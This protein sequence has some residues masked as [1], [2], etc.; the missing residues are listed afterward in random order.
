[1]TPI[2]APRRGAT[3]IELLVVMA[4]AAALGALALA[5]LPSVAN[6]EYTTRGVAELQ[7]T[8]KN[9]QAMA[10]ATKL[11]RGVRLLVPAGGTVST[12]LQYIEMPPIMIPD[13]Q[14]LVAKPGDTT[15][16]N[17]KFGPQVLFVYELYDGNTAAIAN[18]NWTTL[19]AKPPAGTIKL[20]H[21]YITGLTPAQAAQVVDG[22]V[23]VLPNLGS[24]S[25]I[26][27][28]LGVTAAGNT[29]NDPP[30]ALPN[31]EV[32]LDVY[33]DA[34]LGG[35][36]TYLAYHF[37]IYGV[38]VPLLAEPTVPMPNNTG[39][40]FEVSR[41]AGIAGA[42]YDI[43][44]APS[45]QTISTFGTQTAGVPTTTGLTAN[46]GVF[47]WVRDTSKVTNPGQ[48]KTKSMVFADFPNAAAYGKAFRLG[49]EQQLVGIRNGLIGGAPVQWPD[50]NGIYPTPPPGS[51]LQDPYT[52][53]RYKM[54]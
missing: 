2:R 4:I 49:G 45:G 26:K 25:R 24:W 28:P 27:S 21:C 17:T 5:L 47:L 51:P 37:G 52:L 22:S 14:V 39:I 20:R 34:A 7:S 40:D 6:S 15:G 43:L 48:P 31:F 11:P 35:G 33:P 36:T 53:I 19:P 32:I 12:E 46:T 44:F 3:L 8:C 42:H 13:P 10:A 29:A 30:G 23:M 54:N 9:A 50:G 16:V 38:P 41:P 18:A 1:M